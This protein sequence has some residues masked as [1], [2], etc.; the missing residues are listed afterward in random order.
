MGILGIVQILLT[1]QMTIRRLLFI[2]LKKNTTVWFGVLLIGCW[3]I[4]ALVKVFVAGSLPLTVM[5][6]LVYVAMVIIP[7]SLI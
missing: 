5:V 7:G 1:L 2:D 3:P 6:L 4:S